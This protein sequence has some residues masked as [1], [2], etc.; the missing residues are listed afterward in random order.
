MKAF[1]D[2]LYSTILLNISVGVWFVSCKGIAEII[3]AD[4]W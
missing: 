2:L 1:L 3:F 4:I